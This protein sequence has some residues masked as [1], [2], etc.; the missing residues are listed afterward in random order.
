MKVSLLETVRRVR[1]APLLCHVGLAF[2]VAG[3]AS[4]GDDKSAGRDDDFAMC[5]QPNKDRVGNSL[6][7]V[8]QALYR[9]ET[10]T[11][12]QRVNKV[13]LPPKISSKSWV[14]PVSVPVSKWRA[15]GVISTPLEKKNGGHEGVDITLNRNTPVLAAGAG[16]IAYA[17]KTCRE[18]DNWCGNGWGNHVVIDHGDGV[19]TRYAHLT[20]PTVAVGA[21]VAAGAS[22]G[23]SGTTGLSDGPHLHFELGIHG[24]AFESCSAP[25]NFWRDTDAGKG[26]VY[27]SR[28][29]PFGAA[30]PRASAINKRCRVTAGGDKTT[31]VRPEAN[32]TSVP[33]GVVLAGQRVGVRGFIGDWTRI[34]EATLDGSGT[35]RAGTKVGHAVGLD[36]FINASQLDLND[37]R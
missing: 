18:G 14:A 37:C 32:M 21:T 20:Q 7:S 26:G 25:Q 16:K 8:Y 23:L 33:Y 15:F 6:Q 28:L 22:I 35:K 34:E 36:A 5:A 27:D 12:F 11:G 4:T 31:N 13:A 29:L 30:D 9:E 2:L 10:G 19:Y 1:V 24:G 3:C 17:L